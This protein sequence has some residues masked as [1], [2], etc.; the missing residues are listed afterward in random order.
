MNK[1]VHNQYL[2]AKSCNYKISLLL[3]CQ[4]Y[5]FISKL[6]KSCKRIYGEH[7]S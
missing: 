1:H 7:L 5:I 6:V 3:L 4:P 2:S